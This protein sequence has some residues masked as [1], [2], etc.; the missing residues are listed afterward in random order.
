MELSAQSHRPFALS[1]FRRLVAPLLLLCLL[2]ASGC[3]MMD[4]PTA[5]LVGVGLDDIGLDAATLRFDVEVA[6][7]YPVSLPLAKLDY[8]LASSGAQ[9]L[10]GEAPLEGVVP[11]RGT[12]TVALP[13]RLSYVE[14]LK[15]VSGLRPGAVVPY[16]AALG[17]SVDAPVAGLL[18]LPLRRT[19]ELPVPAVPD[20]EVTSL[21]WTDL[22]LSRAAGEV[23]LRV[24]NRNQFPIELSNLAYALSLAGTQVADATI[25]QSVPFQA[26]GDAQ[27]VQIPISFSPQRLGVAVLGAL[28]GEAAAYR[29]TGA[30]GLQ[31]PYGPM[32][33]P[34]DKT[35]RAKLT[36]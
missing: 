13:V 34:L 28:R 21:R 5:R 1:P 14:L 18:R 25:D 11:A 16:D 32:T 9:F 35:G 12:R 31:S 19:G 10:S 4:E 2:L 29:L 22:S 6:N 30:M 7:P 36:R 20:V 33:L 15:A 27:T 26:A 24:V 8:T 23:N 17:L 3:G